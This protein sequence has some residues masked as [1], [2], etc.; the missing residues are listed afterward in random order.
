[1]NTRRGHNDSFSSKKEKKDFL[2]KDDWCERMGR[3]KMNNSS[4][5]NASEYYCIQHANWVPT[6]VKHNPRHL[7][8]MSGGW[9]RAG[10]RYKKDKQDVQPAFQDTTVLQMTLLTAPFTN[11]TFKTISWALKTQTPLKKSALP[12]VFL[13]YVNS[14]GTHTL[15]KAFLLKITWVLPTYMV[16]TYQNK[17][18][19]CP[20]RGSTWVLYYLSLHNKLPSILIDF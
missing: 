11:C 17:A 14:P 4:W 5:K 20:K 2:E 18:M 1:M 10:N 9:R 15:G 12:V 16:V 3:G 19:I 6:Y 13:T 8:G 7:R